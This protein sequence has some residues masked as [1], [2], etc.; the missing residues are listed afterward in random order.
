[1]QCRASGVFGAACLPKPGRLARGLRPPPNTTDWRLRA[2]QCFGGRQAFSGSGLAVQMP[3]LDSSPKRPSSPNCF[4]TAEGRRQCTC[5]TV[6]R[7]GQRSVVCSAAGSSVVATTELPG[8][9]RVGSFCLFCCRRGVCK[10][11]GAVCVVNG[12]GPC[13]RVRV[14][15]LE[16]GAALCAVH[17]QWR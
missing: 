4:W 15:F 17:G 2:A 3:G 9:V 6:A 13:Q 11:G 5:E 14:V 1:M 8:P 12:S 10:L 7:L 16:C